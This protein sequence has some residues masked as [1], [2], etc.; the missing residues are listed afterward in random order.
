MV[1]WW[2]LGLMMLLVV[3][4]ALA[5]AGATIET[6]EGDPLWWPTQE[7]LT[8]W[9]QDGINTAVADE[10]FLEMAGISPWYWTG[11][12]PCG[13][14]GDPSFLELSLLM[15]PQ[16]CAATIGYA[17]AWEPATWQ[18]IQAGEPV[19]AEIGKKL[20]QAQSGR[21]SK[22]VVLCGIR[23]LEDWTVA[24]RQEGA[25]SYQERWHDLKLE[26]VRDLQ[27]FRRRERPVE[28]TEDFAAAYFV[29]QVMCR[30]PDPQIL[31]VARGE[32]HRGSGRGAHTEARWDLTSNVE[33]AV[34]D[35]VRL[36]IGRPDQYAWVDF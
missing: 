4:P 17:A 27:A 19:A 30:M 18:R 15:S 6:Y 34:G 31:T 28:Y 36:V 22:L 24:I 20:L 8:G 25:I 1:R 21:R 16:F 33:H 5:A 32:W 35:A 12:L 11:S 10:P 2:T 3:M 14:A 29:Q 26:A 23:R 13:A 7:M 9:A